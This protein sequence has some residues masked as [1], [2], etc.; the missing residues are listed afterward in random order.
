MPQANG[1]ESG[2]APSRTVLRWANFGSANS[3]GQA[4]GFA[5]CNLQAGVASDQQG[6]DGFQPMDSWFLVRS[7]TLRC[8]L[9]FQA[10]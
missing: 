2:L 5:G 9:L 1:S 8:Q 7:K 6:P 10:K 4:A 3:A